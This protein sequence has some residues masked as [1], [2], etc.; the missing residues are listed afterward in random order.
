MHDQMTGETMKTVVRIV[1]LSALFVAVAQAVV[2]QNPKID[3]KTADLFPLC[4]P[5]QCGSG[6]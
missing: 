3:T 6:N 5:R 4:S 2:P 1:A